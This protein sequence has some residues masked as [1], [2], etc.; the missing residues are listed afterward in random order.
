MP[1]DS[2]TLTVRVGREEY[3]GGGLCLLFQLLYDIALAADIYIMRLEAVI[4]IYSEG[5]LRQ[6]AYM[7]L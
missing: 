6:G 4:Y 5:A 1:R 3:S 2:L 7:T